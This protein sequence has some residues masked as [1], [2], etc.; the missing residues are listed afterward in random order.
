MRG[1][2]DTIPSQYV[3]GV[4]NIINYDRINNIGAD[5]LKVFKFYK[6]EFI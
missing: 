6:L 2:A 4:I 1:V 5:C 3:Q